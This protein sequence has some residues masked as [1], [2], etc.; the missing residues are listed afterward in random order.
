MTE[1]ISFE[2]LGYHV[3]DSGVAFITIDVKDRPVNVLTPELHKAIGS[4]A[5]HLSAD[6]HAVGAVVHS[7]KPSFMAGGDLKRIV[8]YYDMQRTPAE[9][10]EQ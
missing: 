6:E 10:Y 3:S 7:G 2:P 4:V 1:P 8:R 5:E 9:A